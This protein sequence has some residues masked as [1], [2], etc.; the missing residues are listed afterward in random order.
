MSLWILLKIIKYSVILVLLGI[1]AFFYRRTYH[2]IAQ[3][4]RYSRFR[5]VATI[6]FALF[7]LPVAIAAFWIP[8]ISHLPA[9]W[10]FIAIYPLYCW[11]VSWFIMFLFASVQL[12]LHEILRLA[13]RF[14]PRRKPPAPLAQSAES[15]RRFLRQGSFAAAGVLFSG[16]AYGAAFHDHVEL[17]EETINIAGLPQAFKGYRIAFLSDIHSSVF[18]TK[19]M[20]QR[21]VEMTNALNADL[22]II[23]GDFVNSMFEEVY[24]FAEAF[25]GLRA[26]GG[27]YGVLGNHDYYTR[28]V[29]EVASVVSECGIRLLRNE[30][31]PL[32]RNGSS[33]LLA[34]V[35]DVG[36]PIRA[37]ALFDRALEGTNPS[38]SKI[39]LCHRPYFFHEAARR[40][41]DLTLSGHTH[42]GQIVL[43]RF[44]NDVLAPARIASPY[45]AGLYTRGE[46]KMYVSR[47]IGTVAIPIRI[48]CP[49]E[50]TLLTLA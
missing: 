18:M 22:I 14:I 29:E 9:L 38:L 30:S 27:V 20:M 42:G 5:H 13:R 16:A 28:R 39:L 6:L 24:P 48:N 47:G 44:G 25:S 21:T 33:I 15:R 34:G 23:T 45:V 2:A 37:A 10:L 43:A 7:S 4:A 40:R 11:H 35:D 17:T 36:N 8:K 31:V 12:V 49:A 3:S 46:S 1:Q 26:P 19:E 41:V 50:L 32:Q